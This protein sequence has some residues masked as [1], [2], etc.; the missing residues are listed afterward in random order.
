MF[1]TRR[2]FLYLISGSMLVS[3]C[4]PAPTATPKTEAKPTAAP[5]AP[6]ATS[7][8]AAAE[9]AE[10]AKPAGATIKIG[11]L[12]PMTGVGAGFG[13]SVTNG[14]TIAVEEINEK[15][16]IAGVGRIELITEDSGSTATGA[17][18]AA[19]KLIQQHKVSVILGESMSANTLAAVPVTARAEIPQVTPLSS[20]PTITQQN[21]KFIFRVQV[22]AASSGQALGKYLTQDKGFKKVA[23]V[24]DTNEFG[25]N[26]A[27]EV[28][29]VLRSANA[30]PVV[31]ETY[32][33]SDKDFSAQL[34]KVQNAG[35]DA[36][37]LSGQFTEGALILTQM[38]QLGI[39]LQA[40]GPDGLIFPKLIELAGDAADGVIFTNTYVDTVDDPKVKDFA[41]KY[42]RKFSKKSDNGSAL[43]Y[44]SI[45]LMAR[46]IE[47]AGAADPQKIA[48]ALSDTEYDGITG[49]ISFDANGDSKRD[50]FVFAVK[51]NSYVLLKR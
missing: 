45:Y 22:T 43:A 23:I 30:G 37:V 36:V 16:G 50:P 13:D 15:G 29:K 27:N 3:A 41:G 10:A 5:A 48:A 20:A 12:S 1:T 19:N 39:Q 32:A 25:T 21:S 35:A 31:R 26:Y 9:P 4:Q 8:P 34:L 17:V 6:A 47:K 38:K 7:V 33:T 2:R 51:G 28:E 42:E 49:K 44:D 18:N 14:A 11:N 40:A 24:N 46:A